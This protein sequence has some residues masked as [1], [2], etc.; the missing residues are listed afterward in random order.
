MDNNFNQNTEI[1]DE[2]KL[3]LLCARIQLTPEIKSKIIQI[4]QKDLN[5]AYLTQMASQHKLTPL[6]YWNLKNFT[7]YVHEDHLIYLKESF[8]RN[9]KKNLLMLGELL[10][11]LNSSEKKG[12][13]VIPYKGPILAIHVYQKLILRD[14]T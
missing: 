13:I 14:F 7:E 11:I 8:N 12:L 2:D 6:L 10:K 1:R 3:L 9:A 5:F 4:L